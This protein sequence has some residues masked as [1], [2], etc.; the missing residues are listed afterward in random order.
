MRGRRRI[1]SFH[2]QKR[3]TLCCV[4]SSLQ[5]LNSLRI[6]NRILFSLIINKN[7]HKRS[8]AHYCAVGSYIIS[9]IHNYQ[10]KNPERDKFR[11]R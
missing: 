1:R 3:V 4:T 2:R 9:C 10:G 7:R 11:E 8:L 6:F 5:N